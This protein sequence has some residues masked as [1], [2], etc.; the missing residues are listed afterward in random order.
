MRTFI[1][2]N[3]WI[4]KVIMILLWLLL[5]Q[6]A[7]IQIQKEILFVSP[8]D[9]L[10]TIVNLSAKK[11]FWNTI[12][13]SLLRIMIGYFLGITA[14]IFGAIITFRIP[15][16]Y[17]FFSPAIGVI[18]AT[19]V[20]SFII[21]ALLWMRTGIVPVFISFLMVFPIIWTNMIA[22]IKNTDNQLLEMAKVFQFSWWKKIKLIYI[23]SVFPYFMASCVVS[24]GLAWKSGIAAEVISNPKFSIGSQLYDSKIYLE[25]AQLFAWTAIVILLSVL[26]EKCFMF[27]MKKIERKYFFNMRK[28]L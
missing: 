9:V 6:W 17:E 23:P 25:T 24:L 15:F 18:K 19:P 1:T 28:S 7:Y 14:G 21:L 8:F 10:K 3:K 13:Y 27:F 20:A 16:A 11:E 2:Q 22:G 4:K 5:W 26:L 12:F